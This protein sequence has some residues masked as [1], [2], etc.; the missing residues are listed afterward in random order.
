MNCNLESINLFKGYKQEENEN[1]HAFLAFLNLLLHTNNKLF[2]TFWNSLKTGI[3]ID[4]VNDVEI[5]CQPRKFGSWDGQI[6]SKKQKW[7]VAIESKIRTTALKSSQ[8]II[9]QI[10][11]K[12]CE[13]EYTKVKLVLLTPFDKDWIIKEYLNGKPAKNINYLSWR[14]IYKSVTDIQ[15]RLNNNLP[16]EFVVDQYKNYL[17]DSNYNHAGIIQILN[18]DNIN[19][20]YIKSVIAGEENR[21]HVPS[22]KIGFDIPNFKVFAYDKN[23]NGIFGYFVSKGMFVNPNRKNWKEWKYFFK[24]ENFRRLKP[25][26]SIKVIR[27]M[28][29]KAEMG[30]DF[31]KYRDFKKNNCPAPYYVLNTKMVEALEEIAS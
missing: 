25:A 19:D 8:L 2:L 6:Y 17:Q 1:T 15:A 22:K 20:E 11:I 26:I 4:V 18:E 30:D 24:I 13:E 23:K 3:K 12:K 16:L 21:W 27:K 29:G 5:D 10:N 7:F 28:L 31:L 9:H 14:D